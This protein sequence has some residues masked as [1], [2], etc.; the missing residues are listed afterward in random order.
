M[1]L[2]W[3]NEAHFEIQ[4]SQGALEL[5]YP[6]ISVLA[7]PPVAWVDANV[8]RKGTSAAAKA[9]LE[10]LYTPA[11]Q[12]LIAKHHYRPADP[13]TAAEH[14]SLFPTLKLFSVADVAGDWNQAQTRFFA[15]GAEFDRIYSTKA[16]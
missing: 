10:F 12:R 9:Y 3:E 11:A 13:G 8:Q 1:H 2:T 5:V 16:E 4:E 6:P 7:E 14:A 15:E